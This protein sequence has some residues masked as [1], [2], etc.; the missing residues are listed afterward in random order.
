LLIF[1]AKVQF[2]YPRPILA[3]FTEDGA[4]R[5][6]Y[7]IRD[8]VSVAQEWGVQRH[9][10]RQIAIR[11]NFPP[12]RST[13]SR[14]RRLGHPRPPRCC[15]RGRSTRVSGSVP[16]HASR[17]TPTVSDFQRHGYELVEIQGAA[18]STAMDVG[19]V[20]G[21]M[22]TRPGLRDDRPCRASVGVSAPSGFGATGDRVPGRCKI[23]FCSRNPLRSPSGKTSSPWP[24]RAS[25]AIHGASVR[26]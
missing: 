26:H 25:K 17:D 11:R 14:L 13:P 19:G 12:W 24:P 5:P 9:S 20:R 6:D 15:A 4:P 21:P 18:R 1:A 23:G 16:R 8:G 2:T 7:M 22:A 3:W 10:A